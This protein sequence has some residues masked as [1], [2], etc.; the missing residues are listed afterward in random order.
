MR[1]ILAVL[2]L[3]FALPAQ[4]LDVTTAGL[5]ADLSGAW[6]D[7]VSGG[8]T[9]SSSGL[10]LTS[11]DNG[12]VIAVSI[13]GTTY[14]TFISAVSAGVAS[15]SPAIPSGSG[16]TFYVGTENAVP[17]QALMASG[18]N[19]DYYFPKGNYLFAGKINITKNGVK[20]H[21][22]GPNNSNLFYVLGGAFGFVDIQSA[23][24]TSLVDLTLWNTAPD[25]IGTMIT[26]RNSGAGDP[27]QTVL[28]RISLSMTFQVNGLNVDTALETSI[29][30]TRF[31][32]GFTA[33]QGASSG[34][35][36]SN[37]LRMEGGQFTSYGNTAVRG[38]G[39]AWSFH[40]VTFEARSDGRGLAFQGVAGVPV[41]NLKFDSCW[42]GDATVSGRNWI[43]V[44][45]GRG[46]VALNNLM[47]GAGG[48]DAAFAIGNVIGF[49][50]RGN[51]IKGFDTA[52]NWTGPVNGGAVQNNAYNA[53]N[54]FER[55]Q[56]NRGPWTT[57]SQN[58][59]DPSF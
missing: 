4:A 13:G 39:E 25:W 49:D 42:F 19:S 52:V 18:V 15:I 20:L 2:F 35:S 8:N 54:I 48:S 55:N 24:Q 45:S 22:D 37:V 26:V 38:G 50:I 40:N 57:V 1:R 16:L 9:F 46:F 33:I 3:L 34:S 30:D 6:F 47:T 59:T 21:G 17:L 41:T 43:N 29:I 53:M 10:G 31:S 27:A 32:G 11:A 44:P 23:Q 7:G 14:E 36:Y 28:N 12:K 58:I 51:A 5:K 56:G